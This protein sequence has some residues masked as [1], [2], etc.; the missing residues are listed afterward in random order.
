MK[1]GLELKSDYFIDTKP[2]EA[3]SFIHEI[4]A[5]H[6]LTINKDELSYDQLKEEFIEDCINLEKECF[7]YE[8]IKEYY[9]KSLTGEEN[10]IT[11]CCYWKPK[12]KKT[13]YV[14][15]AINLVVYNG[16]YALRCLSNN[17]FIP[18]QTYYH[19]ILN[20]YR[21]RDKQ[22][23]Y[24]NMI[25]VIQEGRRLGI[26]KNL[27]DISINYAI[28]KY[29]NCVAMDLHVIKSGKNAVGLYEKCKFIKLF[30]EIGRA[31]CRERVYGLG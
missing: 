28:E 26:G 13:Q 18:Y 16:S 1:K 7:P 25:G 14:I 4:I 9:T 10:Y 2:A 31:S 24:V 5:L 29:P 21:N 11:F 20:K 8:P 17:Q 12:N 15:G 23:I 27:I 6:K 19:Q 22:L 3:I 30:T